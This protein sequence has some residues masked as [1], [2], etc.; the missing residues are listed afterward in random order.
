MI[1]LRHQVLHL[2]RACLKSAAKCP[3]QSHRET[4]SAYVRLKFQ[5]YPQVDLKALPGK[6]SE[7]REELERMDYYH[8]VYAAGQESKKKTNQVVENIAYVSHCPVCEAAFSHEA[9]FCIQC[10]VKRTV[11]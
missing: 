10:G 1:T 11:V 8:S 7:G 9:K 4:M 2:Y 3:S 6:L 5:S